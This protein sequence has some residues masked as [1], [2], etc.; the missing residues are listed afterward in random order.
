VRTALR[1]QRRVCSR[2]RAKLDV[3]AAS[4]GKDRPAAA[5]PVREGPAG[6]LRCPGSDFYAT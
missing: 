1:R 4:R 6:G 2:P 5:R 3:D